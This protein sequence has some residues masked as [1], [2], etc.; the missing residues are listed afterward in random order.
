MFRTPK[1]A[2]KKKTPES[3]SRLRGQFDRKFVLKL[4]RIK[5]LRPD[6]NI[7]LRLRWLG[8]SSGR[9]GLIRHEEH[10]RRS[11]SRL[12]DFKLVC[13]ILQLEGIIQHHSFSVK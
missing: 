4:L 6:C 7:P 3:L 10:R 11:F 13:T 5:T 2:L 12:S 9:L 8:R 1:F